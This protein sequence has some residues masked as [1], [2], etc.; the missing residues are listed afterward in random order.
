[1]NSDHKIEECG[2]EAEEGGQMHRHMKAPN[3]QRAKVEGK[4]SR[5]CKIGSLAVCDKTFCTH[6]AE[7]CRAVPRLRCRSK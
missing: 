7:Q 3:G 5:H 2:D 4:M 1:M 6:R